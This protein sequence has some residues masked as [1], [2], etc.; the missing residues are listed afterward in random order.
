MKSI[1]IFAAALC[2]VIAAG[3][4]CAFGKEPVYVTD[5][6]TDDDF[7]SGEI[8][9]AKYQTGSNNGGKVMIHNYDGNGNYAVAVGADSATTS[10]GPMFAIRLG[11]IQSDIDL[12]FDIQATA[13]D[14]DF[15]LKVYDWEKSAV[16]YKLNVFQMKNGEVIPTGSGGSGDTA[17]FSENQWYRF[18]LKLYTQ[19]N[20]YDLYMAK[21]SD[22]ALGEYIQLAQDRSAVNASKVQGFNSFQFCCAAM[23]TGGWVYIDNILCTK[24]TEL[25]Y[26]DSVYQQS[27]EKNKVYIKLGGRLAEADLTG[28]VMLSDELGEVDMESAVYEADTSVITLSAKRS[29]NT[30]M[31]HTVTV[32]K[33]VLR[34]GGIELGMELKE[35]FLSSPSQMDIVE[36]NFEETA[37][38][39]VFNARLVN[40]TDTQRVFILI[41]AGDSGQKAVECTIEPGG[42]A[43]VSTPPLTEAARVFAVDSNADIISSVIQKK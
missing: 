20:K 27:G 13:A 21:Y 31:A 25:P 26:I 8:P 29:L 15:N 17:E 24:Q 2:A 34:E 30:R 1:K 3:S 11:N 28:K 38:G 18:K 22:G 43:N 32:D 19:S 35:D 6:I 5:I 37:D 12:E 23:E 10:V 42:E 7:S 4:V 14:V 41:I 36:G 16:R 9:N 33:S 39:T 40:N